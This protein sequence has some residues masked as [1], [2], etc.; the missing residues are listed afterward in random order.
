MSGAFRGRREFSSMPTPI[1]RPPLARVLLEY[2]RHELEHSRHPIASIACC[3]GWS[4]DARAGERSSMG[5]GG[6]A[7]RRSRRRRSLPWGS[8]RRAARRARVQ[9]LRSR[10]IPWPGDIPVCVRSVWRLRSLL[11]RFSVPFVLL[12]SVFALL[13]P[14]VLLTTTRTFGCR[15]PSPSAACGL[16]SIV[17]RSYRCGAEQDT[18][19]PAVAGRA[20]RGAPAEGNARLTA[21]GGASMLSGVMLGVQTWGTDVAALQRRHAP[22]RRMTPP[23]ERVTW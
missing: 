8:F 1:S 5:N 23:T 22:P 2:I 11:S 6:R 10:T 21:A 9:P 14:D 4:P 3:P 17:R 19:R 16:N 13:Q 18:A 20:D 12:R 7:R 15:R